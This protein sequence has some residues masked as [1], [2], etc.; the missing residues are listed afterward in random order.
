MMGGD[1]DKR[2]KWWSSQDCFGAF[3][4]MCDGL[5]SH[6]PWA[7]TITDK[8]L[9]FPTKEEASYPQLLCDHV[10]HTVKALAIEKGFTPFESLI[11]QS[12]QQSS[13]ALQHVN[14]GFLPRG[15]KLKPLV[16]EFSHYK[17]WIL[18]DKS[19]QQPS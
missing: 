4:T 19:K 12:K 1:R 10:A 16:S 11:Q 2:T 8:G 7:S 18:S 15:R 14:M 3:N 5:H 6:K 13:A 9:H 17:T